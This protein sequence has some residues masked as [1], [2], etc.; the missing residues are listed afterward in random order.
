[1]LHSGHFTAVLDACVL[2]PAPLRD[3]L[4]SL[5]YSGLYQPKWSDDIQREWSINLLKERTDLSQKNLESTMTNMNNAFPDA[6]VTGYHKLIVALELPDPNDNHVLAASI[7]CK[8]DVIITFN[9]KDFPRNYLNTYNIEAQH[10]DTFIN[11]L[12]DLEP[13]LSLKALVDQASRLQNPP[14]TV[15]DVLEA[16][17]KNR[18]KISVAKFRSMIV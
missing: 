3:I 8:A 14:R 9:L 1:M 4:L 10:P 2:Y 11:N 13:G 6:E 5:A 18:L 16:L 7:R 17:E 12:I 15:S